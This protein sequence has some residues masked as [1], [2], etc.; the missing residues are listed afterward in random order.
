MLH[1]DLDQFI[2]AVEVLR[3]PEL[4]GKPIIVGGR[5]DPTERAV[6][7]TASYEARAFGVGSGMPLRVAARKVPDAVILPVDHEAYLAASETVMATLRALPGATVQVLG[8]DEAFVGTEAEVP[9]AYARQVQA[10]VLERTQLHCSVGIGDTLVRAKVATGFGKP[11]GVFR[12]TAGNWLAVM[13]SRSTKELWGV[14]TKVSGRLAK[15]SINTVAELAASDPQDL[16]PEFGPRMGPW[17]AALGRGDGTSVVDDT[18]WVARGHSRETT[19]QR[20]LTEAAQVDEAVRELTTRVLEDVVA[21]GRPVVGLTLKVRY[22]PFVTK[23]H[24]KKI[25]ETFDRNEILAR[26]LDLVAGIEAG[27]PIRLLGLRAEMA[28]PDEA[29]KQHTPTRGGW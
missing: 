10:A 6:V 29:R 21:E 8:W 22:A 25:P 20:D 16:V 24:A 28:M 26:A 9:E 5:G 27:R 15:L 4:A 23:T 17:Y 2:A 7:S 13:G 12:L 19:F 11:A 3:R 14:G 1:V 18:P